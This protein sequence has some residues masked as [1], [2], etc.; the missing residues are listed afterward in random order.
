M[1]STI[2][3]NI[4]ST[5]S[6]LTDQQ[7]ENNIS[8]QINKGPNLPQKYSTV[9]IKR[10]Y[11]NRRLIANYG[12]GIP[13]VYVFKDTKTEAVYVGGSKNLYNRVTSY[14]MPSIVAADN[15]RVN[16]Y[17]R[18]YGYNNVN[19]TLFMLPQNTS[20]I[21]IVELEQYFISILRPDLNVDL[22]AGGMSGT[23]EPMS[24]E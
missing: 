21:E 4:C 6:T 12:K 9:E 16:R 24:Q 18:S 20:V 3:T 5:I 22:I 17:F 13:G 2:K 23:H 19:L 7:Q 1:Q 14:F 11:F 15:R 8:G 10:A